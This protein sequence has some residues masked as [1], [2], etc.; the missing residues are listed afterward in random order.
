MLEARAGGDEPYLHPGAAAELVVAGQRLGVLGELH[1]EVAAAF[2][3]DVPCAVFELELE[4]LIAAPPPQRRYSEVSRQ[5]LVRRDVAVLMESVQP[6]GEIADAICKTGG[7]LVVSVELFDRY[8][9]KGIP[10]GKV[11]LA[12]RVVLQRADRALKETEITKIMDRIRKM[13]VKR[14]GGELR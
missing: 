4:A 11:S 7:E 3:I 1:P 2:E 6:S 5:P 8:D 9:G 14:F 13:L 10:A 12:F